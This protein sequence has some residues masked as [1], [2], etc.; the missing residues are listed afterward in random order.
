MSIYCVIQNL[1]RLLASLR[2]RACELDFTKNEWQQQ[3]AGR[4]KYCSFS[5]FSNL[6]TYNAYM[7]KEKRKRRERWNNKLA[8]SDTTSEQFRRILQSTVTK[9]YESPNKHN[10]SILVS[11][12]HRILR[13]FF[14]T[15]KHTNHKTSTFEPQPAQNCKRNK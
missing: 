10:F 13:S 1:L 8:S 7:H 3:A 11:R 4:Q 5:Q 9:K 12:Y 6:T 2:L 15:N 14:A